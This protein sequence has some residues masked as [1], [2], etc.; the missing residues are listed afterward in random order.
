MIVRLACLLW[1]GLALAGVVSG[2]ETAGDRPRKPI[3]ISGIYPSLAALSSAR[4]ECGIGGVVPWAGSLWFITYPAHYGDGRLW[5]VDKHLKLH[6]RPESI[7]GTHAGRMIHRESNQLILGPYFIDADGRVR[8]TRLRARITAVMRHLTDPKNKVYLF[9]MEGALFEVD[10]HTQAFSH[11]FKV[12]RQ[13]ATGNHG[14]GGYTGQGRVVVANNG[15]GGGLAEWDG[16]EWKV[17]ERKQFCEVTGPGGIGGAPDDQSLEHPLWCTGW[18]ARSVILKV[19]HR[20]GWHTYRV[21]KSSYTHDAAH[22]WF[23]EWPRIREVQPGR[24]MMDFHGM[25]FDFPRDFRPGKTGGLRPIATH[26][27]MVPDFCHWAGRVVLGA[28]D[29]SVMGNPLGGQPQSN[30]WFGQA[31]DLLRFGKP[32]GW[33]GPWVHDAVKA[34]QPSDPYLIGGFEKRVV[35]LAH[36]AAEEVEFALEFDSKG[37][38]TW[39]KY[40]SFKV[41]PRG[42]VYHVFAP[43]LRAGWVRITA[44]R[45]CTATAYFHYTSSGG[46]ADG[47]LGPGEAAKVF[48]S[49]P[50]AGESAAW[51]GGV[52]LPHADRLWFAARAVDAKGNVSDAGLYEIDQDMKLRRRPQLPAN[53]FVDQLQ[54]KLAASA[55]KAEPFARLSGGVQI[56]WDDASVIVKAGRRTYRL[57]KAAGAVDRPRAL[58]ARQIREVVTERYLMN[59]GGIFYEVP[60]QGFA[61]LRPITAHGK[62]ISDYCTWRGLLVMSGGLTS[63]KP[64]GHYFASEAPA[65]PDGRNVGLWFGAVDDLWLFGKPTGTGGPW[66]KTAVKA[67]QASDPYLMTGFDKKTVELSHDGTAEVAFTIEVD[68]LRDGTWKPYKIIP[69]PPGETVRHVFP[70]GFSAHWVRVTASRDSKATALFTYE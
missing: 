36:D 65:G 47:K 22:G 3:C 56:G 43:D 42:Y 58:P 53:A 67:G 23:T 7:G 68:F 17:V 50:A 69:V 54:R 31:A 60:R 20:G 2:A 21:P 11:L 6:L 32:A 48:A 18:D 27:R 26:I 70:D 57:P 39:I 51:T 16:K 37:D 8:S 61:G 35:H 4:S 10:V 66:R 29:T 12:Q 34:G 41:P 28:D 62:S 25:F 49:L 38:G 46:P 13:G 24:L 1:L 52:V 9:D 33:G 64:D 5:Q 63:A 44:N 45:D 15:G 59:C 55:P 14:K 40:E 19:R 30:L